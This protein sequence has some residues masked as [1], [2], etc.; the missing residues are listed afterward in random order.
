VITLFNL[1][2]PMVGGY[3][4]AQ[5]ALRRAIALAYDSG[6]EIRS[7]RRGQAVPAQSQVP[8]HL[9]GYDPKFKSEMGEFSPAR[10]NALLDLYGY[11]DRNGD[12]WREKPDGQ[13]L[14]ISMSTEP[15]IYNRQFNELWQ[16][17]LKRI[18][19]RVE[20][21]TA[22]WSENMKAAEA[23]KL[24]MWMLGSYADSTDGQD[25]LGRL[26]SKQIG[27]GNLAQFRHAEFDQL[28][29]RMSTLPDGPEREAL[30]LRAKRIG[31]AYMPY[32]VHVHRIANDLLHPWVSG[33]RRPQF[34]HD[35]WQFVDL[36][37]AL[38]A[39]LTAS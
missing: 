24:Q 5:V 28:Y 22:Q 19:V 14:L 13:P 6:E 33:Y 18:G 31:I 7:I 15:E 30:L 10:A 20:F 12:G 17:C 16:K 8:P 26:Y 23:G 29:E 27:S 38:R 1:D 11:A 32:K 37:S 21:K 39:R 36:D 4:P 3:A 9:S 25:S 35:W 34:R 2:D